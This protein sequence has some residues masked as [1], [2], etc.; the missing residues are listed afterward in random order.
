[1]EILIGVSA[2]V[3]SLLTFYSGFGLGTVLLPLFGLYFELPVAVLLTALVHLC[4]NL[5]KLILVYK[6]IHL[7]TLLKFLVFAVPAG[8]MGAFILN[9]ADMRFII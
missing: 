8:I 4:N 9:L 7:N 1:M 6:N 5:F 3:F 2:F